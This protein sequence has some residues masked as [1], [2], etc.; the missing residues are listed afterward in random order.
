MSINFNP[1][2]RA[3]LNPALRWLWDL[4]SLYSSEEIIVPNDYY[5]QIAE[6]KKVLNSDVS[7]L[8]NSMLDFAINCSSV[9]YAIETSNTNLTKTLNDW[10]K[11]IN[12]ELVGK[13]PVGIKPLAREYFRER[14]KASSFLV[15]RTTWDKVD[16]FILPTRMW[17]VDG[18]NIDVRDANEDNRIIGE[19]VYRLKISRN[20]TKPLPAT[21]NE[22]IFVQKPFDSW[23]SLYPTPYLIQRGLYKNLKILELIN[24]KG[25]RIVGKAL[26]YML[27]LK[28]GT[29]QTAMSNNPDFIYSEEDLNKVRDNFKSFLELN[30]TT[31]GTPT[32]VTN[33]DTEIEHLIPD[34]SKAINEALYS[35]IEKRILAGLGLIDIADAVSASRRDSILNPKPFIGEINR[36]IS[37]FKQLINDI[38]QVIVDKNTGG[39]RK[40][41]TSDIHI[42]S[43]PVKDFID[44]DIKNHVRSM[45]D[46]GVISKQTYTDLCGNNIYFN[47]EVQLRKNETKENLD[48][49]MYAPIIQNTENKPADLTPFKKVVPV[50]PVAKPTKIPPPTDN[51]PT[52]KQ[53]IEKKNYKGTLSISL[54]KC[55]KCGGEFDLEKTPE[56][57][58]GVTECPHCLQPLIDEDIEFIKDLIQSYEM[59]PYSG[60]DKEFLE[61]LEEFAEVYEDA[62]YY[63]N[64]D[65]PPAVKKYPSGA[66]TAF[67]K[68]WMNAFK[69]YKDEQT[70]FRVAWSVLKKYLSKK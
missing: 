50:I 53:G 46:R 5:T 34:Y 42:Y 13:I 6:I 62:P 21:A 68:A 12:S 25:E 60:I 43:S 48:E 28:K 22:L 58:M 38:V 14:W 41:F 70:A 54:V 26:E 30:K 35:P 10:I 7:G 24:K 1:N 32:H 56:K 66:Q 67:R 31:A 20:R 16:G 69:Y 61:A 17:F 18:E 45:Y 39:H 37:D 64:K 11:S 65:L 47:L 27:L 23:S 36:G 51:V 29:E 4:L 15:L 44:N 8:V 3:S 59:E 63:T 33:F 49:V 9:D 2:N 19:E 52:D 57:S 55:K 40:Y